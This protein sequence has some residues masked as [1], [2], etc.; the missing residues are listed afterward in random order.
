[1]NSGPKSRPDSDTSTPEDVPPNTIAVA[2][3]EQS[4]QAPTVVASG[5]G[6]VA[7]KILEL[8]FANDVRVREDSDLVQILAAVDVDSPIP[9]D[10]FAAVAEVLSY[11]YKANGAN[12][13][14][15]LGEWHD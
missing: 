2:L 7:E 12:P 15:G 8:A 10:A 14:E 5:R 4:G 6:F 3:E 9:T 11:L 13:P 1:M